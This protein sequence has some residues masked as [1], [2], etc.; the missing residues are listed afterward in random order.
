MD[1]CVCELQTHGVT[2]EPLRTSVVTFR[3]TETPY[4]YT[5]LVLLSRDDPACISVVGGE[6][7]SPVVLVEDGGNTIELL[8]H[9]LILLV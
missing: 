4:Q 8:D 9:S 2:K 3:Y 1:Y 7:S 5:A 6:N